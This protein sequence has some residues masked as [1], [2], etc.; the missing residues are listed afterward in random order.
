MSKGKQ[1]NRVCQNSRVRVAQRLN[2]VAICCAAAFLLVGVAGCGQSAG[3][4]AAGGGVVAGDDYQVFNAVK[5][6]LTVTVTEDGNVESGNNVTIKCR[7]E[8]GA[9]ILEIVEEE[10]SQT[11]AVP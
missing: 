4:A 11:E 9:S 3:G 1:P 5:G 2:A 10:L 7:V 8:G 6:P